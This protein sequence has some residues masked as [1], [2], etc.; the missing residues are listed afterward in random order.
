MANA[1]AMQLG[2]AIADPRAALRVDVRPV[3]HVGA[4]LFPV[5]EPWSMELQGKRLLVSDWICDDE[6]SP[7]V[8]H[9]WQLREDRRTGLQSVG[10]VTPEGRICL[11]GP[12]GSAREVATLLR[13][14]AVPA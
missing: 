3:V 10:W 4:D 6:A 2:M 8:L 5:T 13:R 7:Y 14:P 12:D 1:A 9:W 11:T